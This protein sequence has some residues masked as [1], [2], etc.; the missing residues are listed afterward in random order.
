MKV[1]P[2]PK[3][4]SWTSLDLAYN[5]FAGA[6]FDNAQIAIVAVR[7]NIR[8]KL[9]IALP[10]VPVGLLLSQTRDEAAPCL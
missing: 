4:F 9:G 2:L 8:R 3:A 5:E 1:M 6:S 7:E 10:P